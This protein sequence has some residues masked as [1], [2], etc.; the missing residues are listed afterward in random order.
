MIDRPRSLRLHLHHFPVLSRKAFASLGKK[1]HALTHQPHLLR[2]F[3]T[4]LLKTSSLHTTLPKASFTTTAKQMAMA[5]PNT[6]KKAATVS[7]MR[8]RSTKQLLS[9]GRQKW[10]SAPSPQIILLDRHRHSRL[11]N[12]LESG[13]LH[14]HRYATRPSTNASELSTLPHPPSALTAKKAI[15]G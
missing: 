7:S 12:N 9:H 3:P 4:S 5:L 13:A 10:R 8:Q 1:R 14:L 11:K 15:S 6:R 2:L